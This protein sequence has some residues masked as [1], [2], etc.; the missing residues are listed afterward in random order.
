MM[1]SKTTAGRNPASSRPAGGRN[2]GGD[3]SGKLEG[4]SRMME[5]HYGIPKFQ[6]TKEE[7]DMVSLP[8][9]LSE[10]NALFERV[11]F[12]GAAD[13]DRVRV[14]LD[15]YA[16]VGGDTLAFMKQAGDAMVRT[17]IA[18]VQY[19]KS[20]FDQD[21]VDRLF[22]NIDQFHPKVKSYTVVTVV[23]QTVTQ[24]IR[25][26]LRSKV[27]FERSDLLYADPPWDLPEGF[28]LGKDG[29]SA[30]RPSAPT[31]ALVRKLQ[32]E[33]FGPLKQIGYPPPH[34]V[35]IKAPTPFDEFSRVLFELTPYLRVYDLLETIP[36]R[37]RRGSIC[38]YFHALV[39][40]GEK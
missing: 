31:Q 5:A 26:D 12:G 16:N 25:K 15:L 28:S 30:A 23:N 21:R 11:V 9:R 37:N 24:F 35:C 33:V 17:R 19:E 14:V 39:V 22:Q 38:M 20:A 6:A 4:V 29:G 40:R 27:G 32:D 34:V 18:S 7:V 1:R 3:T 2:G 36:V 13:P 10:R 8:N